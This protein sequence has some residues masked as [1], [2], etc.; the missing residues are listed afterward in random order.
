MMK[1]YA[2][3]VKCLTFVLCVVLLLGVAVSGLG[4]LFAGSSGM[5]NFSSFSAWPSAG[6]T[7]FLMSKRLSMKDHRSPVS[8]RPMMLNTCRTA[9]PPQDR[10]SV[11]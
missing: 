5:Y 8:H 11:V 1:K 7:A 6:T 4:V 9:S 3:W 10:K 2:F